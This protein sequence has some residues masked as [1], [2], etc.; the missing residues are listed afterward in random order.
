MPWFD[1]IAAYRR[2]LPVTFKSVKEESAVCFTAN[3]A[4]KELNIKFGDSKLRY[5]LM[6]FGFTYNLNRMGRIP[7]EELAVLS[8]FI[9]LIIDGKGPRL[10]IPSEY[11]QEEYMGPRREALTQFKKR[12]QV[13][14]LWPQPKR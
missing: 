13:E 9:D 1:F 5:S 10:N 11:D 7:V 3:W 6:L 8:P 12:M 2:R 14:G 4:A